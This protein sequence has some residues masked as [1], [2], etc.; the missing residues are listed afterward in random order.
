M[1]EP[2]GAPVRKRGMDW[3]NRDLAVALRRLFKDRVFSVTS[4]L[5]LAICIGANT[6]LFAVVYNVLLRPLPVPEPAQIVLMSN[7]YPNAGA[8]DSSNS[9]VPDYYDRL[10]AVPALGEQALVD[11]DTVAMGREDRA[12]RLEVGSVT[13][14]FFRLLGVSPILG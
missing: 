10:Q 13:P 2:G 11:H 8:E 5:T 3:L 12:A 6:A 14:S 7:R 9:G 4:L 1:P